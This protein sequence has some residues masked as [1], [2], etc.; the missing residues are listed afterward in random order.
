[1]FRTFDHFYGYFAVRDVPGFIKHSQFEPGQHQALYSR[2]NEGFFYITLFHGFHQVRIGN[3]AI[4]V[5][6]CL[7]PQG[8][9]FCRSFH[10]F[11][12]SFVVEILDGPAVGNDIALEAPP[13]PEQR[14]QEKAATARFS[15][16]ALIGAHD[17]PNPAFLHYFFKVWSIRFIK[18]TPAGM[19][20]GA[21]PGRFRTTVNGKVLGRGNQ[22]QVFGIVSL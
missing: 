4:Q 11:M 13:V 10:N 3:P 19:H 8:G 20:I 5:S 7:D 12:H 9:R 18:I 2:V 14:T 17:G 22:F 1:V 15:P 16:K 21:V 6:A